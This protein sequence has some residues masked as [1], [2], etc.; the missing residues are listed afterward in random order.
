M[1]SA[2]TPGLCRPWTTG[3]IEELQPGEDAE[4]GRARAEQG[5]EAEREQEHRGDVEL[6]PE[7]RLDHQDGGGVP[8]AP[9]TTWLRAARIA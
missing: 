8:S 7:A 9:G 3:V 4:R 2:P 1:A 5:G 6:E